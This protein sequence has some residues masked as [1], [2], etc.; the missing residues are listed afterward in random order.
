MDRFQPLRGE[1]IPLLCKE[2]NLTFIP[3]TPCPSC[4]LTAN[5]VSKLL[6]TNWGLDSAAK[7]SYWISE[8]DRFSKSPYT[9][10]QF[11]GALYCT[12][13][14]IGFIPD[15]MLDELGITENEAF[16]KFTGLKRPYGIGEP[17]SDAQRNQNKQNKSE[18][19]TPRKPSD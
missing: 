8:G 3:I 12:T 6:A 14:D 2:M 7:E 19:S 4:G 5:V 11:I 13:C 10:G 15:S 16:A 1:R 17:L 18:I 9:D